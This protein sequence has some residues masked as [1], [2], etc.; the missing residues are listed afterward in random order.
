MPHL[1]GRDPTC[2]VVNLDSEVVGLPFKCHYC[3][4]NTLIILALIN[5]FLF[6]SFPEVY[7]LRTHT[8]HRAVGAEDSVSIP[9]LCDLY[10]HMGGD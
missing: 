8:L 1:L 3:C 4:C 10:H 6:Y 2:Y 9:P 7:L 5:D